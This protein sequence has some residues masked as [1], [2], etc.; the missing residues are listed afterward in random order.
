MHREKELYVDW[1]D[2]DT[3]ETGTYLFRK[4]Q[5]SDRVLPRDIPEFEYINKEEGYSVY[6]E[7]RSYNGSRVQ[8]GTSY[9]VM[10]VE[11]GWKGSILDINLPY[12]TYK[13]FVRK[14]YLGT[15]S[16]RM[17]VV[18]TYYKDKPF[19]YSIYD[20]DNNLYLG[21]IADFLINKGTEE[22]VKR[23]SKKSSALL[24][25]GVDNIYEEY[26]SDASSVEFTGFDITLMKRS[27]C[28][29]FYILTIDEDAITDLEK[30]SRKRVLPVI[31]G[32]WADF[33][34]EEAW[35]NNWFSSFNTI[36][37]DIYEK[38][39][40][41][42]STRYISDSPNLPCLLYPSDP[43]YVLKLNRE[44]L[45]SKESEVSFWHGLRVIESGHLICLSNKLIVRLPLSFVE[46]TTRI[47]GELVTCREDLDLESLVLEGD[48]GLV[49]DLNMNTGTDDTLRESEEV[50]ES[51]DSDTD[52]VG[53][54]DSEDEDIDEVEDFDSGDDYTDTE[55]EEYLD[56]EDE[57]ESDLE[58]T[59]GTPLTT[60]PENEEEIPEWCSGIIVFLDE[61]YSDIHT[62]C[63]IFNIEFSAIRAILEE[64]SSKTLHDA[65]YDVIFTVDTS[66]RKK[67]FKY[68]G[69]HYRSVLACCLNENVDV[70]YDR[71]MDYKQSTNCT[72]EEAV[73]YV[74]Q[75]KRRQKLGKKSKGTK[76]AKPTTKSADLLKDTK[77]V[78]T[79]KEVKK[80][81]PTGMIERFKSVEEV[82]STQKSK[83][84]SYHTSV[85]DLCKSFGEHSTDVEAKE[86]VNPDAILFKGTYYDSVT[87]LCKSLGIDEY[88]FSLF[89]ARNKRL[90]P[91]NVVKLF[92]SNKDCTFYEFGGVHYKNLVD[93]CSQLGI[94][95]TIV[96]QSYLRNKTGFNTTIQELISLKKKSSYK[97]EVVNSADVDEDDTEEHDVEGTSTDESSKETKGTDDYKPIR[98]DKLYAEFRTFR[99]YST[100]ER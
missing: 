3:G 62:F 52:D 21:R 1:E 99:E 69:T 93:C 16:F 12:Y 36:A 71:V 53:G 27:K 83:P 55:D 34:V 73:S 75:E 76:S 67:S 60:L 23:F 7:I 89:F 44:C 46:Y 61:R 100:K 50:I 63:Y 45:D 72:Y 2:I 94:S 82:T 11:S 25:E 24:K 70:D 35:R 33:A 20:L 86:P 10:E 31:G 4:L 43:S 66:K 97:V 40:Y 95:A 96:V 65:L 30:I 92:Y 81:K 9:D 5:W 29:F 64:D 37:L 98:F 18:C 87:E 78:G 58:G 14:V 80:S 28:T 59:D 56:S 42:F 51:E 13:G 32:T 17:L 38:P 77:P 57:D 88:I 91:T 85:S 49:C 15:Y 47:D 48:L 8:K 39:S 79:P 74:F 84:T 26:Y 22:K 68:K 90:K 19:F 54:F 41:F 6:S